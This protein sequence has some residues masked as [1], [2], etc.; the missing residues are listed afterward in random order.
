MN[1]AEP[2]LDEVLDIVS[3]TGHIMLQN[4]AEIYRVEE[5]MTRIAQHFGVPSSHFFV[6]SNGIFT[7]ASTRKAKQPRSYANVE[8]IP[9]KQIQFDKVAEISQLSYDICAGRCTLEQARKRLD[10]IKAMPSKPGWEQILAAAVGAGGFCAVF[11]GGWMDCLASA[12]VGLLLHTFI[13]LVSG[14][15]LSKILQG[16]CNATVATLLSVCCWKIGFAQN[17]SNTIIGVMML[18]VPGVAFVNGVRDLADSDYIAGITRMTDALL[19]FFC[20]SIGVLAGFGIDGV[21]TGAS[22][23]LSG[24]SL[25]PQT[26]PLPW[27]G[28][29]ALLATAAFACLFGVP[30]SSYLPCGL[31]GCL[32]WISFLLLTRQ[33]GCSPVPATLAAATLACILARILAVLQKR[34]STLYLICALFPL[35]PGGGIFWSTYYLATEHLALAAR[36]G[37]TALKIAI[38]IVLGIIIGG[39]LIRLWLRIRRRKHRV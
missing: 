14:R 1:Q 2:E 36:T 31:A 37:F 33:A 11:G 9:I 5:T 10:A 24:M 7:T 4:G 17:L 23:P 39:D 13:L 22:I 34:P 28:L 30:R 12:A 26:A 20:I 25:S 27:Q 32:C 18:L 6:L 3:E 35:I 38:A 21:L 15:H 19:G 8:F 16:I 29:L